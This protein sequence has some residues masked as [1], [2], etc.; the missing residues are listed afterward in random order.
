MSPAVEDGT[1]NGLSSQKDSR[2]KKKK[3][4]LA[5]NGD[6]ALDETT[7]PPRHS[8]KEKKETKDKKNKKD[9]KKKRHRGEAE[10]GADVHISKKMKKLN[11]HDQAEDAMT[12]SQPPA[13]DSDA[14]NPVDRAASPSDEC[15]PI[16]PSDTPEGGPK[17][18]IFTRAISEYVAVAPAGFKDTFEYVQTNYLDS[19]LNNFVPRLKGVLVSY[20]NARVSQYPD[21]DANEDEPL[22]VEVHGD[23]GPAYCWLTYQAGVFMPKSGAFME[24]VVVLEDSEHIGIQCWK[25]FNTFI[26]AR[27]LPND[28][29]WDTEPLEEGVPETSE[30]LEDMYFDEKDAQ[31][32][33]MSFWNSQVQPYQGPA[34]ESGHWKDGNGNPIR[35]HVIRFRI[36]SFDAHPGPQNRSYMSIEGTLLTAEEDAKVTEEDQEVR[37]FESREKQLSRWGVTQLGA[38]PPP[39]TKGI[40]KN[41]QDI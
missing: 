28:W 20:K 1:L 40:L 34:Q 6:A 21:A 18:P 31:D 35:G 39:P 4:K 30:N 29:T 9:K 36:K 14:V 16:Q 33:N 7:E 12:D 37:R 15:A 11:V 26:S 2:K 3:S 17:Y 38:R 41:S 13:D 23:Y 32:E 27:R 24:G 25:L 10:E 19:R 5:T 8:K 22:R